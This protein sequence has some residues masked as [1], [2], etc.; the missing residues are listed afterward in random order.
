MSVD[1][2]FVCSPMNLSATVPPY[3][4]L[5]LG[6]Y[7]AKQGI[8]YEILDE[9]C[10]MLFSR[11]IISKF[12]KRLE[13][14]PQA[15]VTNQILEKLKEIQPKIVG[16]AVYTSDYSCVM[17]LARLIKEN[18]DCAIVVGNA[19]ASICPSDFI[20]EGS[21]IDYVVVGE[22]EVTLTE[23]TKAIK[24]GSPVDG[25]AGLAYLK[26]GQVVFG[27]TRELLTDLS[28]D[29]TSA[30]RKILMEHYTKPS[31]SYIRTLLVRAT[32]IYT[33]RGCPF[34]CTFCAANVVW[35]T[36]GSKRFVRFRPIDDVIN[37]LGFLRDTYHINAFVINDDAFTIRK[38]RVYDFCEK[39]K[40]AKI[41]LIWVAQSRVN[42]ID[43]DMLSAMKDAGCIQIDFGVESASPKCLVEIDKRIKVEDSYKAFDLCQKVGIRTYANM[44]IN[45]PGETEEDIQLS[46]TF[47]RKVRPTMV[48]WSITSPYPGTAI[49]EKYIIPKLAKDEYPLLYANRM[50]GSDRLRMC[51]HTLDLHALENRLIKRHRYGLRILNFSLSFDRA[52]IKTLRGNVLGYCA[53]FLKITI[54]RFFEGAWYTGKRLAKAWSK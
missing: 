29:L 4:Y 54:K 25:I 49:N 37:E 17:D 21:C 32:G 6:A 38:E 8:T 10:E 47:L 43:E 41:D 46:E 15:V 40:G 13:F 31:I 33:G 28:I 50:L 11:R 18:I 48:G 34:S 7:L 5:Y 27:P 16:I 53:T 45:I 42:Q 35:G 44:L 26:N 19:H 30:Y 36:H 22:G 24:N 3:H 12:S 23:L 9:K 39:L 52:Y 51:H 1:I 2:C 14:S 20:Y